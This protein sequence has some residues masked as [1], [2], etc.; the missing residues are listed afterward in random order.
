MKIK[1]IATMIEAQV[2]GRN[3]HWD[4]RISYSGKRLKVE[5][6]YEDYDIIL[7]IEHHYDPMKNVL[8]FL[9]D[10]KLEFDVDPLRTKTSKTDSP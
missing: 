8:D 3:E 6:A 4:G 7:T 2:I 5:A 9:E 10:L 1:L